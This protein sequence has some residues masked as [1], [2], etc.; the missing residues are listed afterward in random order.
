MFLFH[1]DALFLFVRSAPYFYV[2]EKL[3]ALA[4]LHTAACTTHHTTKDRQDT[5]AAFEARFCLI[6]LFYVHFVI[7]IIPVLRWAGLA[8]FPFILGGLPE[9]PRACSLTSSV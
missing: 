4:S 1:S 9:V 5:P 7:I 3:D 2:L 8:P 6:V